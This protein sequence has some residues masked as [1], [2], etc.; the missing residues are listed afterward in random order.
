MSDTERDTSLAGPAKGIAETGVD[1]GCILGGV[2][3]TDRMIRSGPQ[4]QVRAQTNTM[5]GSD[6][7]RAYASSAT[8]SAPWVWTANCVAV[9]RA[10]QAEITAATPVLSV[11]AMTLGPAPLTIETIASARSLFTKSRVRG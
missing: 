5:D 11:S 10:P 1:V 2:R 7:N 6:R 9:N 3:E 4:A 8:I